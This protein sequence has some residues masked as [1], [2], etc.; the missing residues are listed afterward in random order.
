MHLQLDDRN[1]FKMGLLDYST[2]IKGKPIRFFENILNI[3]GNYD[4]F[5]FHE[6]FQ[7]VGEAFGLEI[8]LTSFAQ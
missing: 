5:K 3:K 7:K 4:I 1:P 6:L 2:F 8:Q